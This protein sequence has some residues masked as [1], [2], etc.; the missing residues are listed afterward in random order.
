MMRTHR[1]YFYK[2]SYY[3]LKTEERDSTADIEEE[4]ANMEVALFGAD[5]PNFTDNNCVRWILKTFET[6]N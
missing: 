4:T 3:I 1:Y 5:P 2:L 6:R